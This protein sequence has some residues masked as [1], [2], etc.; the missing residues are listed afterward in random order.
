MSCNLA[1][2]ETLMIQ[3]DRIYLREL[4]IGDAENL[5]RMAGNDHVAPMTSSIKSPW[6]MR[7]IYEWIEQGQFTG[8]I[9][10]RLGVCLN[11]GQLIGMVGLGGDYPSIGYFIDQERA[12]QGFATEAANLVIG[13]AFDT[14]DIEDLTSDVFVDNPASSRVLKKLGFREFDRAMG[15]SQARVDEAPVILYRLT[16][17]TYEST[18]K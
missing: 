4:S 14:F 1:M 11:D 9:G 8:E 10:F 6:H 3:G 13:Y 7:D 18:L 2:A 15:Q 17:D 12:G 5:Q 16:R